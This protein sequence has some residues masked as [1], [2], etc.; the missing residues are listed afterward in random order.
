MCEYQCG[1]RTEGL[2]MCIENSAKVG[3]IDMNLTHDTTNF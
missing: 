2:V 3:E 1:V